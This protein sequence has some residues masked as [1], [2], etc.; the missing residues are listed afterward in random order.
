MLLSSTAQ[1]PS[2]C[3]IAFVKWDSL[4]PSSNRSTNWSPRFATNGD[5]QCRVA[6]ERPKRPAKQRR[7][8]LADY[9]WCP[10]VS[11]EYH[12]CIAWQLARCAF[13]LTTDWTSS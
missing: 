11:P 7:S 12:C 3:W 6:T 4:K 13:L 2:L 5:W 10:D 8:S 9:E 1:L